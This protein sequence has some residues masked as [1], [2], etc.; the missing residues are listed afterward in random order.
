[1]KGDIIKGVYPA[2]LASALINGD[3]TSLESA[4]DFAMLESVREDIGE[5]VVAD[6]SE[7]FFAWHCDVPWIQNGRSVGGDVA[8]YTL[9]DMSEE[10]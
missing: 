3:E 6:V 9:V 10:A 1:M 2:F 4:D 8:E 7:P 5:L